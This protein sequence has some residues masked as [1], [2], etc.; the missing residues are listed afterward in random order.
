MAVSKQMEVVMKKKKLIAGVLAFSMALS[1]T[2]ALPENYGSVVERVYAVFGEDYYDSTGMYKLIS[3]GSGYCITEFKD[4]TYKV[5]GAYT[6]PSTLTCSELSG[7]KPVVELST[8]FLQAQSNMTQLT[9]PSGVTA[10]PKNL[11][12]ACTN[13]TNVTIPSSV[14]SIGNNAF[15]GCSKLTSVSI[16]SG[17]TTIGEEAFDE[18]S[19]LASVTIP[20]T[21]TEIGK[22]AF[23]GCPS[24]TKVKIPKSV[25]TIGDSAFG[26]A[27][28]GGGTVE[29]FTIECYTDS[30]A[31]KYA[32]ANEFKVSYI[33]NPGHTHSYKKTS[34]VAATCGAD[35]Y[36]VYTCSCG[37]SYNETTTSKTNNHTFGDWTITSVGATQYIMQ[38]TCTVCGKVESKAVSRTN[39]SNATV[40]GVKS[41]YQHT[42]SAITID[43]DITV[44]LNGKTLVKGTDYTIGYSNN[45]K[46]GTATVTI[47]GQGAYSGTITVNF[48][49]VNN[50]SI[51]EDDSIDI[52]KATIKFYDTQTKTYSLDSY[53]ATY[54]GKQLKPGF[55]LLIDGQ[56]YGIGTYSVQYSNNIEVG[57]ATITVTAVT[58][59][60]LKGTKTFTF[61]ITKAGSSQTTTDLSGATVTLSPS[62]ATYTGTAVKPTPTVK[63]GSTTLTPD[64][65]YTV[66][67]SNNTNAGTATVTI[68]GKGNYTGTASKTFTI[69]A[70]SI[71][72]EEVTLSKTSYTYT[73]SAN[74]P[75]ATVKVNGKTLTPNTDYTIGYTNNTNV[76]TATV[77][78]TGKGNYTGTVSKTF[79]ISA[80]SISSATVSLPKTSYTY[81]GSAIKPTPTV[82]VGSTTLTPGT[83]YT[84]SY[85]DNT[86]AGTATVT[87]TGKGNYKDSALKTFTI[88]S[89]SGRVPGDA[90][91][92][93]KV[94]IN[95]VLLIQQKIAKWDVNVIEANCDVNADDKVNINDVLLIQQK[96]AKWDVELI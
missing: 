87:I 89:N 64:T 62:S 1:C 5:S 23:H 78:I 40:S 41:S 39:I 20:D 53:T 42:G 12:S 16:P 13:L 95:D 2:V 81:T 60:G 79:T 22:N 34:S 25:T 49:I 10:I 50:G 74:K 72:S 11:C 54:T 61:T 18:C 73:G 77:T 45:T 82:K 65:D 52:S 69:S 43:N 15:Y 26:Y 29:D 67:Y 56:L 84:V 17:V 14:T 37:A 91:G 88:T 51:S 27:G 58:G 68:T 21:V 7:T 31:D 47:T 70:V 55:K 46:V 92:D 9:I 3:L 32:T 83:D 36:D 44:A 33:D 59:K 24:L 35:G 94:N 76:G 93:G 85:K 6:I 57:T 90:N 48:T 30:A 38:S 86:N 63:V 4:N 80:V 66:S 8:G 28:T 75:T 71:S 19:L 96:I